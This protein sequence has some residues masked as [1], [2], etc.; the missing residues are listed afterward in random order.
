MKAICKP[1]AAPGFAI[2]DTPIPE[3][4][5]GEVRLK[6]LSTSICG[7]DLNITNWGPWSAGR[8][9]PPLVYGHEC[10]GLVDALGDGVT[11]FAIGDYVAPEMHLT[12]WK[13]PDG[14]TDNQGQTSETGH[15][16]YWEDTGTIYGIDRPG[17][18]AEYMVIPAQQLVRLPDWL[19]ASWGACLDSL[20]NAV[21]ACTKVPVEGKSVLVTGCGPLGVFSVAV[22]KAL[23][24]RAVYASDI[25]AYRRDKALE[26]GADAVFSPETGK[27]SEAVAT[28]ETQQGQL[29]GVDVVIEMSGNTQAILDGLDALNKGGQIILMGLTKET[30]P[31]ELNTQVIF[32][33]ATL[34]GCNGRQLFRTWDIMLDLLNKKALN[35]D[36]NITHHMSL[37]AFGDAI[38]I[39]ATGQSGKIVMDV[40]SGDNLSPSV[41]QS[42]A[43]ASSSS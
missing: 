3:P 18:F 14:L 12:Y 4:G 24:A 25:T 15:Y 26:A 35:L 13:S 31:I 32:K 37:D 34:M 40:A 38:A 5:P 30:T 2:I 28:A 1:Q 9:Q 16:G 19:P 33:E 10:C 39:L 20:G 41:A 22:A 21:H 8:I 17:C 29:A 11:D 27:V 36:F 6:I 23:G 42:S 7:T 43:L